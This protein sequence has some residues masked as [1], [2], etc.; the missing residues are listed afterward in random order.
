MG[1][2]ER[3]I[4]QV[5]Q[6]AR[7]SAPCVIFFDE[8]DSICPRRSGSDGGSGSNRVVNQ[9]LTEMDGVEGRQGVYVMG[10]TNRVDML[11]PAILRPGRLTNHFF[12]DLPATSGRVDILRKLTKNRTRPALAGDVDFQALAD[13]TSGFSGA[14]LG[15]LVLRA[16]HFRF[17]EYCQARKSGQLQSGKP[18]EITVAD[19]HF[20]MALSVVGP[21][22]SGLEKKKYEQMKR[23]YGS[24]GQNLP[25]A[26]T[27]TQNVIDNPPIDIVMDTVSSPKMNGSLHLEPIDVISPPVDPPQTNGCAS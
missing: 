13:R 3:A 11:D 10:A 4:R 23:K 21:S 9:L 20:Q 6:R 5:F 15:K 18:E 19:R 27:V 22:V 8:I 26:L 2:S 1:E 25:E 24:I 16:A 12:V 17:K 14:D 7:N